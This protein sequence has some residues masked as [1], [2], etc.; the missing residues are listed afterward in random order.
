MTPGSAL[1]VRIVPAEGE[2]TDPPVLLLHG[3]ASRGRVDWRDA[4]WVTP[5]SALG[6]DVL[7]V[8]LPGHGESVRPTAPLP[9][10]V[11][12]AMLADVAVA[13]GGEVDVI[14]YSLGA[15]LAWDLASAPGVTVRRL[16]LGGLSPME[17]FTQVDTVAARAALAG[18]AEPADPLTAMMLSMTRLPGNDPV[19]LFHVIEG[20]ASEAFDPIAR[21]PEVPVLLVGGTDDPMAQCLDLLA[22]A[23]PEATVLRVPGDHVAALHSPEFRSAAANFLA[24]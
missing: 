7:V 1:A 13:A 9:T 14:G 2:L 23:L 19:A 22:A 3:F 5:L 6:R 15:R 17:P 18:G 20:F 11:A 4:E 24:R 8:D 21:P 12:V 10:S 16:V